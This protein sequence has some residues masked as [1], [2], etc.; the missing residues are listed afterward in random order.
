MSMSQC[1]VSWLD[2]EDIHFYIGLQTNT[3]RR[4]QMLIS[5]DLYLTGPAFESRL[6][7]QFILHELLVYQTKKIRRVEHIAQIEQ[8]RNIYKMLIGKPEGKGGLV[9]RGCR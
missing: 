5:P 1:E 2:G 8:M 7:N 6:G 9:R 4:R 3:E